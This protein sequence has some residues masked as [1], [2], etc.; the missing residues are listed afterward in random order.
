MYTSHVSLRI[1]GYKEGSAI[2]GLKTPARFPDIMSAK[3]GL[4][5]ATLAAAEQSAFINLDQDLQTILC[6]SKVP[7][8]IWGKLAALGY[9]C[10]EDFAEW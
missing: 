7:Y 6:G 3:P 10:L 1:L 5:T 4:P 9:T 8:C 2:S